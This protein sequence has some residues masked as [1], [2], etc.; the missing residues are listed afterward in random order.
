MEK[1][2]KKQPN[3]NVT[4]VFD[5]KNLDYIPYSGVK[6]FSEFNPDYDSDESR[7]KIYNK[8]SRGQVYE[9]ERFL[10]V[11]RVLVRPPVKRPRPKTKQ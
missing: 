2:Q 4:I 1:E 10:I 5:K 8:V 7:N 11:K 9:D 3:T 6:C